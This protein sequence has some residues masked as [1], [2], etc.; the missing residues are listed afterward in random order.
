MPTVMMEVETVVA[1]GTTVKNAFVGERYERAPF[2]GELDLGLTGSAANVTFEL[3]VGGR[4]ANAP[5]PT[6]VANR[7]PLV[8]DDLK[9]RN[10]E[11]EKGELIQLTLVN[12][13]VANRT[14]FARAILELVEFDE[15][16]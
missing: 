11:M 2:D 16:F 4:S 14:V 1:A 10:V 13:D 3:N 7:S 8:P 12:S 5:S 15:E 6:G 9:L